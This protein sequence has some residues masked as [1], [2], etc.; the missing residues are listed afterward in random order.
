MVDTR[1]TEARRDMDIILEQMRVSKESTDKEMAELRSMIIALANQ[2]GGNRSAGVGGFHEV[3]LAAIH[4]K[5]KAL[6]WHK[7]YMKS[8]LTRGIP[9][10][11]EYVRALHDRFGT[12]LYEDPMAELMNFKQTGSIKEYLD[13]FD[14]LLNNVELSK[15][16]AVSFF[17]AGLKNEI[18]LQVRMF[19]PK[20]LQDAISLSK[21]Q[22]QAIQLSNKRN[23]TGLLPRTH[24]HFPK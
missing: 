6:Q 20:N 21:L 4:L 24:P 17:F 23:Y 22:E 12:L 16:Y 5:E 11:E 2:N 19:K 8:K 1:S 18:A 14:E 3:K 15:S 13:K 7:I 10:W 9:L